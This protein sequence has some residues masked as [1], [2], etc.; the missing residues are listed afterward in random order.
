MA[1]SADA[2]IYLIS[3]RCICITLYVLIVTDTAMVVIGELVVCRLNHTSK[4]P[5]LMHCYILLASNGCVIGPL[6][7]L[8][9]SQGCYQPVELRSVA[10][11]HNTQVQGRRPSCDRDTPPP[12]SHHAIQQSQCQ[13]SHIN[14]KNR[15]CLQVLVNLVYRAFKSQK[16]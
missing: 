5:M 10:V 4:W 2:A 7:A 9:V 16:I 11:S 8:I 12:P 1:V 14:R 15:L 3:G 13:Q 6:I